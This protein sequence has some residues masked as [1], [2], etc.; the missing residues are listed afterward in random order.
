MKHKVLTFLF[1]TLLLSEDNKMP[2]GEINKK[3][4]CSEICPIYIHRNEFKIHTV[5]EVHNAC[6]W[7]GGGALPLM[8][9]KCGRVDV[10]V[11]Y[12]SRQC[13]LHFEGISSAVN[14]D[15]NRGVFGQFLL[16]FWCTSA[17]LISKLGYL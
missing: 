15:L 17:I 13:L 1:A 14:I 7:G 10:Y 2:S 4:I 12:S 11:R 9:P 3:N 16:N 5:P 8:M 6:Q